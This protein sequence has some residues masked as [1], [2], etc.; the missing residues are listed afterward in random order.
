MLCGQIVMIKS[1]IISQMDQ[2]DSKN[3]ME[4]AGDAENV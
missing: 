4:G 1:C 2:L 3:E